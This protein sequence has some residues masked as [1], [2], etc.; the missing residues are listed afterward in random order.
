MAGK[1]QIARIERNRAAP[2]MP[3]HRAAQVIDHHLLWHTQRPEGIDVGGQKLLHRLREKEL[4]VHLPA[5]GQH[6]DEEGQSASGVA[7][8]DRAVLAPVHL[9]N[10][11]GREGQGEESFTATGPD[12]VDVV[13]DD[14]DAAT[15]A[16]VFQALEDLLGGE[17]VGIEPADDL[18]FEGI[19]LAGARHAHAW[20][21]GTA[22]PVAHGLD[23]QSQT[24]RQLPDR[25]VVGDTIANGAPGGVINHSEPLRMACRRATRVATGTDSG[26]LRT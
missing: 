4:D 2:D 19:E 21:I 25:Q 15:V 3:Q 20:D 8:G 24:F 14:A 9:G 5:P 18:A 7:D 12:S 16:E 23:I 17:R 22:D 26:Q 6:H 10:L 1:I 11:A 13:L